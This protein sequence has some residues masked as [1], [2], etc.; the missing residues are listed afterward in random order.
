ALLLLRITPNQSMHRRRIQL[1]PPADSASMASSSSRCTTSSPGPSITST[2]NVLLN[3]PGIDL[4]EEQRGFKGRRRRCCLPVRSSFSFL[5]PIRPLSFIWPSD[6]CASLNNITI[7][8]SDVKKRKE[9]ERKADAKPPPGKHAKITKSPKEKGKEKARG[10]RR[11][12]M[13]TRGGE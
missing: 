6:I 5:S 3:C 12:A 1:A 11:N 7:T 8:T 9:K 10:M 2:P 13:T 4:G